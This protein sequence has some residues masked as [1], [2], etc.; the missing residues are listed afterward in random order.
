MI[1][2]VHNT[3]ARSRVNGPG[4]RFVVWVQGCTLGC[5]GCFN[6][7][8]CAPDAGCDADTA[9]LTARVLAAAGVEGLTLSGGEPFQQA[10]ACA[11]LCRRVREAGLS[12]FVYTGYTLQQLRRSPDPGVDGLLDAA[13]VLVDGP[14]IAG[15]WTEA[16]WRGS[17][18]QTVH[19]LT[20]RY[21]A[22]DF[23]LAR[24]AAEAEMTIGPAGE[25]RLTGF[26][27]DDVAQRLTQEGNH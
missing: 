23:D 20:D 11:D 9:D 2:R 1:L 24:P 7:D 16:L 13:D 21:R 5:P 25:I 12:V 22:D 26:P 8:A 3:I 19:F 17:D 4:E 10:Q 6:P 27:N 18:N 14:F 15:R